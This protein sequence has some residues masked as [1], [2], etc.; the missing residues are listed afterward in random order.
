MGKK[1]TQKDNAIACSAQIAGPGTRRPTGELA[2]RGKMGKRGSSQESKGNNAK[3]GAATR[4]E[5]KNNKTETE[6][7]DKSNKGKKQLPHHTHTLPPRQR[8]RFQL[9][10]FSAATEVTAKA[11]HVLDSPIIKP[12]ETLEVIGG[13]FIKKRSFS[14]V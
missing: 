10:R 5:R 9:I 8:S 11:T 6:Q 14:D 13:A 2:Q 3:K 7:R 4:I 12:S 1:I